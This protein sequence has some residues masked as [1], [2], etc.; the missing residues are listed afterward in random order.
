MDANI[1]GQKVIAV[2]ADMLI[3]REMRARLDN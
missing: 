2:H 1:A 3:R